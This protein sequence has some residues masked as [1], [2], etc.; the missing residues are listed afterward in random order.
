MVTNK[1]ISSVFTHCHHSN[2]IYFTHFFLIYDYTFVTSI[3]ILHE[4][5][6]ESFF[7]LHNVL[8]KFCSSSICENI[9]I[10]L[11]SCRKLTWSFTIFNQDHALFIIFKRSITVNKHFTNHF[12][13]YL[14]KFIHDSVKNKVITETISVVLNLYM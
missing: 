14:T 9:F 1:L 10:R 11:K 8:T 2:R 7:I 13:I 3:Y 6:F 12:S 5:L 4:W